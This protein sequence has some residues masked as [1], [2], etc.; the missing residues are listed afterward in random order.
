MND[1]KQS[2][3]RLTALADR[4]DIVRCAGARAL[5]EDHDNEPAFPYPGESGNKLY[6]DDLRAVCALLEHI[7]NVIR[8]LR[9]DQGDPDELAMSD[10][11]NS[12]AEAYAKDAIGWPRYRPHQAHDKK[13]W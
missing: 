5:R 3:E 12:E 2:V 13:T 8:I 6:I 4:N 1:I 7:C 10:A 11:I 9:N